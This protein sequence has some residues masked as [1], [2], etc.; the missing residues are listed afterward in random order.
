MLVAPGSS[1]I[2]ALVYQD[3]ASRVKESF[4][5]E[6]NIYMDLTEVWCDCEECVS[7]VAHG[8]VQW[9]VH[10]NKVGAY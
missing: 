7:N 2:L 5:W 10:L 3:T 6:D 1:P 4:L 8:T 9:G